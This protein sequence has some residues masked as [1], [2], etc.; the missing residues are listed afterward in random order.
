MQGRG[1][2]RGIRAELL[3]AR[4]QPRAALDRVAEQI[5]DPPTIGAAHPELG[6]ALQEHLEVA[7]EHRLELHDPIEVG[8]G[9]AV[10]ARET[11]TGSLDSKEV[12]VSRNR[13][14]VAPICRST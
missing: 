8:D 1:E 5:A 2:A 10:D 13:C 3:R 14:E 9:H 7:A 4:E 12:M 6:S 11:I